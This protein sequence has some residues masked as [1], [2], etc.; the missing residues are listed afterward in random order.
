M[1]RR[2]N[3]PLLVLLMNPDCICGLTLVIKYSRHAAGEHSP[4]LIPRLHPCG[5]GTRLAFCKLQTYTV[6][7]LAN[8]IETVADKSNS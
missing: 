6:N 8:C 1:L 3:A 4:S 5:L 2:L 7:H